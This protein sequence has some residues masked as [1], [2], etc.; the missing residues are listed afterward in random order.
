MGPMT[1]LKFVGGVW[2]LLLC[3]F[4]LLHCCLYCQREL[5][6]RPISWM[7]LRICSH[8]SFAWWF[9]RWIV[10]NI[11]ALTGMSVRVSEGVKFFF[12]FSLNVQYCFQITPNSPTLLFLI[13]SNKAPLIG[14]A[15][16]ATSEKDKPEM[17]MWYMPTLP[18]NH[19]ICEEAADV[20]V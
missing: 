19:Y 4:I 8:C 1:H 6:D 2:N 7:T 13:T 17:W 5:Q 12:L 3:H 20:P 15:I 11:I 9:S 18:L 10:A 16:W 14:N